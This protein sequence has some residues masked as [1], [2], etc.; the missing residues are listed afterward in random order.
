MHQTYYETF[1]LNMQGHMEISAVNSETLV[2]LYA[3]IIKIEGGHT[4]KCISL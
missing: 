3:D 2:S 4:Y 1:H